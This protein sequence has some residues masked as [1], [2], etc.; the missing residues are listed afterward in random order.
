MIGRER[1]DERYPRRYAP[2]PNPVRIVAGDSRNAELALSIPMPAPDGHLPLSRRRCHFS[3][4]RPVD[5]ETTLPQMCT[6]AG[7]HCHGAWM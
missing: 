5:Y 1:T 7:G 4:F 6:D 2:M 3:W